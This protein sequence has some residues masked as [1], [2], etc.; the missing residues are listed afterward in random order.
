MASFVIGGFVIGGGHQMNGLCLAAG[1]L[2][3]L[4]Q[5]YQLETTCGCGLSWGGGVGCN[6]FT[7]RIERKMPSCAGRTLRKKTNV[8]PLKQA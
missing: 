5:V 7:H 8:L 6:D 3:G 2:T 4:E 1:Q